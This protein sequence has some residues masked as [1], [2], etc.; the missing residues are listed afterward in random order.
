[1]NECDIMLIAKTFNNKLD[2]FTNWNEYYNNGNHIAS[3]AGYI[4]RLSGIKK[5]LQFKRKFD[6]ADKYIYKFCNTLVYKYNLID[7]DNKDSLIH[8]DHVDW[9]KKCS[10]FQEKEIVNNFIFQI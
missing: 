2:E 10:L 6:L 9:H 4:I 5:I 8:L 7:T 3:T 1:M